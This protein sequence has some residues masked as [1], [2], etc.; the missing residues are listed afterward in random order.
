[1]AV[2]AKP[3]SPTACE[4]WSLAMTE[5]LRHQWWLCDL[6]YRAG[7]TLLKTLVPGYQLT[8]TE[9]PP[10]D[11]LADLERRAHECARQGTALPREVHDIRN[12]R[13]IDWSMFPEWAR[14]VDPEVFSGIGHEG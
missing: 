4:G 8:E 7:L 1:M 2:Q 9:S 11:E 5:V 6:Q 12:R 3:V 13:H 14:P 10:A